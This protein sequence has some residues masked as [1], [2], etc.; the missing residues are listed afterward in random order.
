MK[1][2]LLGI[3]VG[4]TGTKSAIFTT[5]GKLVS[6]GQSD[7]GTHHEHPGWAEQNPDDWW[8]AVCR[9]TKQALSEAGGSPERIAA[10]SVSSQAPA[11][12]PLDQQGRTGVP[13]KSRR[14][15]QRNV[16]RALSKR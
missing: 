1:D 7:Y 5:E 2:L 9:A 12:L 8:T 3:D 15:W 13:K 4:T 14:N 11:M 10:A 16:E 6:V